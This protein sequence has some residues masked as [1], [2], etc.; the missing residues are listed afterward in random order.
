MLASIL[1]GAFLLIY[2]QC[3]MHV[4]SSA[5]AGIHYPEELL[6]SPVQLGEELGDAAPDLPQS[7]AEDV[8]ARARLSELSRGAFERLEAALSDP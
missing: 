2:P 3:L 8:A 7:N 1:L 4:G 5:V 6:G